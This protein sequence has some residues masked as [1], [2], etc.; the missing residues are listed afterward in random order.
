LQHPQIES[1]L[2]FQVRVVLNT[3][4]LPFRLRLLLELYLDAVY[5]LPV[6]AR[7]LDPGL[8]GSR[9]NYELDMHRERAK[10]KRFKSPG[11]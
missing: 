6:R 7:L 10:C 9:R 1:F 5:S 3:D 2:G 8:G 4:R 11:V